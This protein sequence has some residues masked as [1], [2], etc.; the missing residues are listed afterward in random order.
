MDIIQ[1]LAIIKVMVN[2]AKV[3]RHGYTDSHWTPPARLAT[4]DN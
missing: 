2:P 3:T 4:T 1:V